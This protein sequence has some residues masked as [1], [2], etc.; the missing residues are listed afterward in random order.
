MAGAEPSARLAEISSS[1]DESTVPPLPVQGGIVLIEPR[2]LIRECLA[3]CLEAATQ[4]ETV[5]AF[6]SAS[7]WAEARIPGSV[8]PLILLG[9][10]DFGEAELEREVAILAQEDPSASIVLLADD[11]KPNHVLGALDRGARGY[12]PTR[13]PFDVAVKAIHL[14]RA[15]GT[16]IPV[17]SLRGPRELAQLE[18]SGSKPEP[19]E[20][21]TAR[22]RAVIDA[23]RQGKANKIIAF[24]LNMREST[25]KVHVRNIMKKL[26]AKNRTE[27]AY[28][29]SAM[30]AGY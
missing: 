2:T 9:T 1:L 30:A 23:L 29:V 16:F 11:M 21:F 14:V 19:K 7:D 12:I 20:Q 24:E 22:Q 4:G 13:M 26:N 3:K 27:V 8:A 28:R 10:A 17:E 18:R 5:H 25:V 6:A 15:G